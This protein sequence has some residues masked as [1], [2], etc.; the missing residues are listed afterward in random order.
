MKTA[1][2]WLNVIKAKQV[3]EKKLHAAQLCAAGHCEVPKK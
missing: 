2:N 3:K 1:T